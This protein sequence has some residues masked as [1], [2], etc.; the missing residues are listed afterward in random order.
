[1]LGHRVLYSDDLDEMLRHAD[2]YRAQLG[3]LL[4]PAGNALDWWPT[5]RKRLIEPMGIAP[6]SVL[7]VGEPIA[8]SYA[9]SL[10]SDGVRWALW[11]PYSPWDLRFAVTMVLS[12]SDPTGLRLETRIPCAIAVEV[13]SQT[14][15]TPAQLTDFRSEERRVG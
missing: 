2:E 8:A 13:Q 11:E 6:R 12:Q 7:P 4:V 1:M 10:Y 15:T 14:R 3:A 5:V 9:E